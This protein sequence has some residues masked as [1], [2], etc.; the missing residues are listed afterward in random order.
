MS[1]D[2]IHEILKL[3]LPNTIFLPSMLNHGRQTYK[4]KLMWILKKTKSYTKLYKNELMNICHHR[5]GMLL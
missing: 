5:K 1:I 3:D 4:K 2:S